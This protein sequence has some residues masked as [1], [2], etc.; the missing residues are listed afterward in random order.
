MLNISVRP[1]CPLT[2]R[3]GGT[4]CTDEETKPELFSLEVGEAKAE[5]EHGLFGGEDVI[6]V[7]SSGLKQ[8]MRDFRFMNY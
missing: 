8:G 1:L 5:G 2:E 6:V 4:N 7:R 3:L